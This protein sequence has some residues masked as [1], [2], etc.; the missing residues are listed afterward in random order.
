MMLYGRDLYG[1]NT[2]YVLST[3]FKKDVIQIFNAANLNMTIMEY[4]EFKS[5]MDKSNFNNLSCMFHR[6]EK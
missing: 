5:L 1:L 6:V 3:A 2:Y 4:D